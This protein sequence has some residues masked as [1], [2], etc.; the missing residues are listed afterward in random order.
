MVG[1]ESKL[2][3][4]VECTSV[5][6]CHSSTPVC[7]VPDFGIQS[8]RLAVVIGPNGAGKSTLLAAIVGFH[9]DY[10]G[11]ISVLGELRRG[12]RPLSAPRIG[13]LQQA[14]ALLSSMSVERN[15]LLGVGKRVPDLADRDRLQQV[16]S[17]LGISSQLRSSD[18]SSLS[19][20]QRR[21]V[22]L[23]RTFV[24]RRKLAVLDE[25]EKNLDD[26]GLLGFRKL[27]ELMLEEGAGLVVATHRP[28]L[29]DDLTDCVVR[30]EA[31]DL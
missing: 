7:R 29:Y 24:G 12:R 27:A 11:H 2:L 1:S 25:P 28:D 5:T 3:P 19:G 22:A 17:C 15:I 18:V 26:D 14:N 8:G 21:R 9:R 4:I 10:N 13:Y 6:L 30:I 23:A 31:D 16:Y 20:G